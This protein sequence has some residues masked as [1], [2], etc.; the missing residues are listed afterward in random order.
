MIDAEQGVPVLPMHSIVI[1]V[2]RGIP[3]NVF[4]LLTAPYSQ[5]SWDILTWTTVVGMILVQLFLKRS[6]M[7]ILMLIVCGLENSDQD[8]RKSIEK[9]IT[10]GF[11]VLFFLL[12]SAYEAKIVS[13]LSN[14]PHKPDV[15]S[16]DDLQNVDIVVTSGT[17]F[18]P[19]AITENPKLRHLIRRTNV[20]ALR[21][22]FT[23][24][25]KVGFLS[26]LTMARIVLR[27][28]LNIDPKT[29][30]TQFVMLEE[31]LATDLMFHFFG[32]RNTMRTRFADLQ[33]RI[34]ESGF[35]EYWLSIYAASQSIQP[36][37]LAEQ[38]P[39]MIKY[40][41]L[42]QLKG[43]FFVLWGFSVVVFALELMTNLKLRDLKNIKD[44]FLRSIL[45]LKTGF[46]N[47]QRHGLHNNKKLQ[48]RVSHW[49]IFRIINQKLKPKN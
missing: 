29:S 36:A 26:D 2:P 27:K 13:F 41:Q 20:T 45:F 3:L 16:V 14:W 40:A 5:Q 44:R 18:I 47:T 49:E 21:D 34:Y 33:Q 6:A 19:T 37:D 1:I 48:H 35:M 11:I 28:Q 46:S 25:P 43:V 31:R 9:V 32:A 17:K 12:I 4:E 24:V 38:T 30:R 42:Q 22:L 7:N 23:A 15:I 39:R 10:L 8:R